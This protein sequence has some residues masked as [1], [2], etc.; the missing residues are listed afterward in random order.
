MADTFT[1]TGMHF[2]KLWKM[3]ISPGDQVVLEVMGAV[4]SQTTDS[5]TIEI[6][7][8]RNLSVPRNFKEAAH[9]GYVALRIEPSVG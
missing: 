1:L 8:V 2:D 7:D 4:K 6:M 3:G 5:I 9:R